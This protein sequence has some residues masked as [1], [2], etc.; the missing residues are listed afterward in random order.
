MTISEQFDAFFKKAT[1]DKYPHGKR[2]C[3]RLG[4]F[5]GY[6]SAFK[7]TSTQGKTEGEME[8]EFMAITAELREELNEEHVRAMY[9]KPSKAK[10]S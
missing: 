1:A 9:S 4:Y 8:A 3:L 6:L 5:A 10:A 2:E 7:G